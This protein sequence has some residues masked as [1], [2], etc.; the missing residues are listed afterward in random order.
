MWAKLGVGAKGLPR[1]LYWWL[2]KTTK[3]PS[4]DNTWMVRLGINV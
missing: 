4:Q 3:I 1:H 2:K